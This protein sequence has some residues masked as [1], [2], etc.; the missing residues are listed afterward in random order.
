MILITLSFFVFTEK[1]DLSY[2]FQST[3]YIHANFVDGYHGKNTYIGAQGMVSI[4]QS[5]KN[6]ILTRWNLQYNILQDN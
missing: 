5:I 4:N 1:I 3:D 6:F 2:I